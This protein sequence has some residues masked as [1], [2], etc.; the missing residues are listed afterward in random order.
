MNPY[1]LTC[2]SVG[3]LLVAFYAVYDNRRMRRV[4]GEGLRAMSETARAVA[5]GRLQ[6]ARSPASDLGNLA[7][8]REGR[9]KEA[10]PGRVLRPLT[11]HEEWALYHSANGFSELDDADKADARRTISQIEQTRVVEEMKP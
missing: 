5:E 1:I 6:D 9:K 4:L 11:D 3:A 2:L 8:G 10:R 7:A